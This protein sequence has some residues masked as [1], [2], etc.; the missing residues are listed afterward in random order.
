MTVHKS[1]AGAVRIM[2]LTIDCGSYVTIF[3]LIVIPSYLLYS[4]YCGELHRTEFRQLTNAEVIGCFFVHNIDSSVRERV[5]RVRRSE[6][7]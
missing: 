6:G 2:R 7:E 3:F 1:Q 5:R 4:D